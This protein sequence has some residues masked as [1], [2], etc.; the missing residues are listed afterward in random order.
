MLTATE[1]EAARE[2]LVE[3]LQGAWTYRGKTKH[4]AATALFGVCPATLHGAL[5]GI[6][7]SALTCECIRRGL[8][9]VDRMPPPV[10]P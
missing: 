7:V 4:R 5:C 1:S 3:L 8:A 6:E 9:R 2:V 10:T